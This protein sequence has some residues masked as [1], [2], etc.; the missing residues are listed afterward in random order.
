MTDDIDFDDILDRVLDEISEPI[1]VPQGT[2][3]HRVIAAKNGE[4]E[5]DGKMV[6]TI[7]VTLAPVEPSDDVSPDE[8]EEF[9]ASG[10]AEG[11]RIF[12]RFFIKDNNDLWNYKQFL[13]AAGVEMAGRT[14]NQ[15]T[16]ALVGCEVVA[17]VVHKANK[18]PEKKPYV[19]VRGF[20]LAA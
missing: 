9:V 16:E 5:Q 1:K 18:D 7:M 12:N 17:E 2:W 14:V 3:R 4:S 19:N 10:D 8:M 6:K 13:M 15:A 20:Q 11:A